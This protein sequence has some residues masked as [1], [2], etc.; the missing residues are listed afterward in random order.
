MLTKCSQKALQKLGLNNNN[1]LKKN[2]NFVF[3]THSKKNILFMFFAAKYP[4]SIH[5]VKS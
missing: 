3:F 1:N 5:L 4:K 2:A